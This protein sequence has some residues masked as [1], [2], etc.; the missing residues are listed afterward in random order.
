MS[1][2]FSE[3]LSEIR[4][5][6]MAGIEPAEAVA[7]AAAD[8][9]LPEAALM[10]RARR[11]YGDLE[12]YCARRTEEAFRTAAQSNARHAALEA[13][14]AREAETI[15]EFFRLHPTA[16]RCPFRSTPR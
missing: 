14:A 8:H 4:D 3:A 5:A 1:D 10:N 16:F 15:R 13:R 7:D 9:G 2:R 12:S 11:A 6:L